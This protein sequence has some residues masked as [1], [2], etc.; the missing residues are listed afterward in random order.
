MGAPLTSPAATLVA[1]GVG[2]ADADTASVIW[3]N[4]VEIV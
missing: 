1:I 2:R 4:R 3:Q